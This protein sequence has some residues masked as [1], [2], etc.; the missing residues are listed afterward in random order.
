MKLARTFVVKVE[1]AE[2][3]FEKPKG[4][5]KITALA[6]GE[7]VPFI[8]KRLKKVSGFHEEDGSEV[9]VDGLRSID[10]PD[11]YIAK[12]VAGFTKEYLKLIGVAEVPEEKKSGETV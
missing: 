6:K 5:D 3:E 1:D 4:N 8:F 7:L 11:D 12:I 9:S 10:L 2:F